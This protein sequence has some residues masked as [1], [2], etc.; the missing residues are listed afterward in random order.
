VPTV[1]TDA[2]A[3]ATAARKVDFGDIGAYLQTL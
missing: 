3:S 2:A 1:A